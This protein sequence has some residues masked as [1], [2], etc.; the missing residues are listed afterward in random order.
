LA[1]K[2]RHPAT[3]KRPV[4]D[5]VKPPAPAGS[6]TTVAPAP[7]PLGLAPGRARVWTIM[8]VIALLA[9]HYGMA[10]RSLLRENP[11]VDEIAHMP[12]GITCWQKGTFK[13]YHHNP[14][15]FKLVA[16]LPVL[17]ARPKTA[18][19][20]HA[21]FWRGKD[22]SQ[23]SFGHAF[24]V[25]NADRYFELFDLARL[26]MPLF[27]VVG[28]FVVFAWSSRLHGRL[29]G[30]LS[31]ALWVFCPNILAHARLVT[32]DA[33]STAMGVAATYVFWRYLYQPTWRWAAAAGLMLGLAQLSKFSMLLLYLVWPFLW[34]VHAVVVRLRNGNGG[35]PSPS[36]LRWIGSGLMQGV[37]IVALS[38]LTIDAGYFFE[39]VGIPLGQYEFGS[40]SLTVPVPPG[41]SRPHNDVNPLLEWTWQFRVNRFRGTW[42]GRLPM[43]LPE[44]YLLGFDEQKIETEGVPRRF[45]DA[46]RDKRVDQERRS[47]ETDTDEKLAYS[48][49][50]DGELRSTGW[51]SYY[52]KTLLYKVPEGTWLLVALSVVVLL[53]ARRSAAGWF[54]ELALWVMPVVI[55][56]SISLLTD[57][58][59]GLRYILAIL[60][61]V[62]IATGNV[63]PWCMALRQS[64]RWIAGTFIA[65][66]LGLTIAASA[67]IHPS[68]L[69]YF[70][71]VSGGPDRAPPHLIDSN[72]D[73]GQDLVGLQRWWRAN[74]PNERIGLAYFGQISPSIFEWRN[75]PFRWFLPPVPPGSA[76]P[77]PSAAKAKVE[78]FA[79]RL[80]PGYYAVSATL[81]Y[82]LPWR[83]YD[84]VRLT[85]APGAFLPAWNVYQRN[86]FRYF[87]QFRPIMPP[88][89]H[90][91][92]VYK[93]TEED[94]ARVNPDFEKGAVFEPEARSNPLAADV[95]LREVVVADRTEPDVNLESRLPQPIGQVGPELGEDRITP[96]AAGMADRFRRVFD[97]AIR[98]HDGPSEGPLSLG[99]HGHSEDMASSGRQHA[100]DLAE[101][102][103]QIRNVLERLRREH[104][105]ERRIGIGQSRQVLRPNSADDGARLGARL[106]VG[107]SEVRQTP[108]DVMHAVDAVDLGDA[109]RLDLGIFD[110]AGQR[111]RQGRG[112]ADKVEVEHDLSEAAAPELGPTGGAIA[113]L[114]PRQGLG[115][116]W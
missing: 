92:Y 93:L 49:Y 79:P 114:L 84:P 107:G 61:Y 68:Y 40:R 9:A 94:V 116:S 100:P 111:R 106:I 58:N 104:Q 1:R 41:M 101:S 53:A 5:S 38:V 91:I 24:A 76:Q 3:T 16:A 37:A 97:T 4:S 60:P 115:Q 99:K 77:M 2:S 11:T 10:A 113:R 80:T 75:E 67:W 28:G 7:T 103:L 98:P 44:H 17:M 32:S 70:N 43:P 95:H 90:S 30:L 50:L 21:R 85:D 62:F 48:V 6:A 69:A 55:L 12:A 89:G 25:E 46:I 108:E 35:E 82:G 71:W 102:R 14:P 74:I 109:Q 45:Q 47:P 22:P 72:L 52:V 8:A 36:R 54:D 88:I 105:V 87:Q 83:L 15:L 78:G 13:L 64:W 57:I 20:Y 31:L 81:L 56:L 65:G 86:A 42:L 63:V 73:W 19:L 66:S 23:A 33:C 18:E 112:V 51:R 110:P 39:G 34:L 26:M 27:T 96:I 59:L 29:G